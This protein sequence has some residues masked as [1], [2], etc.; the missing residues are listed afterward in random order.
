MG[1]GENANYAQLVD[2]AIRAI[3]PGRYEVVNEAGTGPEAAPQ[4]GV[5]DA[6]NVAEGNVPVDGVLQLPEGP[7]VVADAV[8]VVEGANVPRELQHEWGD[9]PYDEGDPEDFAVNP[10]VEII[11]L[12]E[13]VG[14]N[15]AGLGAAEL[16]GVPGARIVPGATEGELL[17]IDPNPGNGRMIQLDLPPLA[18]LL[19]VDTEGLEAGGLWQPFQ[20]AEVER[21]VIPAADLEA[22]GRYFQTITA[23]RTE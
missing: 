5:F 12:G 18:E 14:G 1:A 15:L 11:G 19:P 9:N 22:V 8:T 20:E 4:E 6:G 21:T 10:E 23:E 7:D 17:L 2:D 3:D 13:G 16:G